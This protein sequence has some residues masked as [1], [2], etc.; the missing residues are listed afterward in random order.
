MKHPKYPNVFEPVQIGPMKM[1]NR[2]VNLP[3]MSGLSTSDGRV[4]SEL[5]AHM[6]SRAKTGAGL[7]IIGDS[8]IDYDYATSHF[9]PLDLGNELNTLDLAK[10][11]EEVHR[12][13]SNIGAELNHGGM[14]SNETAVRRGRRLSPVPVGP[15]EM[16]TW[17]SQYDAIVIDRDLME[18][19]IAN[20]CAAADRLRRAG[21]DEI[22]IH[23]AHDWL[24]KQFLNPHV[25]TRSDEYGG[26]LLEN[27][28]RF[29][30]EVLEA[31]HKTV[32]GE[33]AIEV[34]VSVGGAISR[35]DQEEEMA[36]LIQFVRAASPYIDGASVSA[37]S[38]IAED[39]SEYMCQSY[40]LP[41][42]V[43][44]VWAAKLKNAGVVVPVTC[45]GSIVTVAEA[46]EILS[47]GQADLVGM[48]RAGLVDNQ[49]FIKAYQGRE[50]DIRP[51]LRCAHCTD[52]LAYFHPIRCAVNPTLGR[53]REYPRLVPVCEKKKVMIVGAG[54]AGMEAA[55]ICSMRGHS[56][57][58]YERGPRIG[59][60][61][62]ACASL[63]DKADTRRYVRWMVEQTEKCGCNI[64]VNTSVTPE[65]IVQEA[66]DVVILAIGAI[67]RTVQIPGVRTANL[68]F[69]EDVDT[70]IAEPGQDV[71]ILGGGLTGSE[72]AIP[73]LRDKHKNVTIVDR[74]SMEEYD[75]YGYGNQT[76]M[77][78]NR[79]LKEN[80]CNFFMDAEIRE[81]RPDGIICR[82][83]N[84]TEQ[85]LHADSIIHALGLEVDTN[86]VEKLMHI[87]PETYAIGDC[88]GK[89][90]SID[91]AIS[92]AFTLA[93]D[94][95]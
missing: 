93:M 18:E 20:Y 7:V 65:L 34:R 62:H 46:E 75:M 86:E 61:L 14:F 73:L 27:R 23:C 37:T 67:N 83:P 32:G 68:L 8:A 9:T 63:P 44:T 48:G 2:I 47:S 56:V 89:D 3:M 64:E 71:V 26:P 77:S 30:L 1:K 58:L 81:I 87:V 55:Q 21:F 72:C 15:G 11:A 94:L 12:F 43:N 60:R 66:P 79:I 51:C 76:W 31:V 28:M 25:N 39:T 41:H 49:H 38:L 17:G 45:A 84:G 53:E 54:P 82:R 6:A 52:H 69:A 5:I 33:V 90:F 35:F 74:H 10:I 50:A 13:G 78:I 57:T 59:G 88:V 19:I 22:L 95:Y 29:P 91:H 4:T 80:G 92:S 70:G 24:L 16:N 85:F 40:Y 36:E 42:K